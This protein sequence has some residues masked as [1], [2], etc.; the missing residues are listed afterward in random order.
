M[1]CAIVWALTLTIFDSSVR[2]VL[3]EVG[4]SKGLLLGC[5]AYILGA[6][7][8]GSSKRPFPIMYRVSRREE[9]CDHRTIIFPT[10]LEPSVQSAVKDIFGDDIAQLK[11]SEDHFYLIRAAVN[12]RLPH[13]CADA[14]RQNDLMRLRENMVIPLLTLW[15]VTLAFAWS[16]GRHDIVTAFEV[17]ASGTVLT[18]LAGGRLVGRASDNRRR[19]VR[20]VCTAF[21]VGHRLGM[22][23]T[24]AKTPHPVELSDREQALASA[25]T[26]RLPI[27]SPS[28][29]A[30]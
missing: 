4:I 8:S 2:T 30:P 15:L 13:A 29:P 26:D 22:F 19:E 7:L 16:V 17:A 21:V 27:K 11:W 18:Y 20:E 28:I 5:V 25:P 9:Y 10:A 3:H 1:L 12:E 6:F 23:D 24:N 14:S